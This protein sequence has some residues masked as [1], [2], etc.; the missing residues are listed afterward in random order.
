MTGPTTGT[1]PTDDQPTRTVLPSPSA[2]P[3]GDADTG[4]Y[5]AG[6]PPADAPPPARIGAYELLG[7]IARGGMGVVYEARHRT[8]NR[9]VALKVSR[10]GQPGPDADE[11]RFRVEVEAAGRLDHPNIVP[12]YEAGTADGFTFTSMALVDGQS[13]AQR[14][15]ARPLLPREAA[16][17]VRQV[18]AAVDYAHR[19]IVIHRDLKPGNILLDPSGQPRVTDFG[20]ARR[21]DGDS[22]L[23]QAGQV[24]GTPS[25]MPPEQ[26]EGKNDLV[27]PAADVYSLGATLYCLLTGRPPFQAASVV[28]TL[29]QD[30]EREPVA[31]HELNP[32]VDRDLDTSCV[33]YLQKRPD[34]RYASAAALGD[35]LQRFLDH[36]PISARPVGSIEKAA[37]W[38]RRNPVVAGSLA[39]VVAAFVLV[40]GSY[41]RAEEARRD[42]V[43]QHGLADL[44][45]ADAQRQAAAER[46]GRYRTNMIAAGAATQLFNVT[47]AE[48]AINDE[49]R[50][51]RERPVQPGRRQGRDGR[52][53]PGALAAAVGRR[54]RGVYPRHARAHERRDRPGVQPGRDAARVRLGRPHRA[55][56]GFVVGAGASRAAGM[57][58]P[59]SNR[60]TGRRRSGTPGRR[61]AGPT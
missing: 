42:E 51:G 30:V 53:A 27:G 3:D 47:A 21:A 2:T 23:T 17:L 22:S 5:R 31:P 43:H 14:V 40:S 45:R 38:C 33:K 39:A 19:H 37:R 52:G 15:A 50:A 41:F 16:T 7:E 57:R 20:L 54:D 28:D 24:M 12:V 1:P 25:Y 58:V 44:A 61:A 48:G 8:L 29:R 18:A 34:R 13:L 60:I 46:R 10:A 59:T 49:R 4:D 35:D 11:R 36:V 32:A 6:E 56:L 9:V 26:A 55:D